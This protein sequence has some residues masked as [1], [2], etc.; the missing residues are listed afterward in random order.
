MTEV[1]FRRGN[2]LASLRV[3]RGSHLRCPCSCH[4]GSR[5]SRE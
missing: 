5:T 1:V 4:S 2:P 3:L